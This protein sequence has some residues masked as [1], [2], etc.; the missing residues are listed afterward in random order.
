[1]EPHPLAQRLE[2]VHQHAVAVLERA[3]HVTPPLLRDWIR[4]EPTQAAYLRQTW[5]ELTSTLGELLTV[6]AD[7]QA[8]RPR[9]QDL[10]DFAPHGYLITDAAG[11]IQEANEAA[12]QLFALPL[13]ELAGKRL[14]D[15]VAP[16]ATAALQQALAELPVT[17]SSRRRETRLRPTQGPPFAGAYVVVPAH[18]GQGQVIE[19]R[20]LVWDT[21]EP[22]RQDQALQLARQA[23]EQAAERATRLQAVIARLVEALTADQVLDTVVHQGAAALGSVAGVLNLLTADGLHLT[24]IG[25]GHPE[26]ILEPYRDF[27][28]SAA[29]P[30]ADVLRSGQPLWIESREDFSARYPHLAES[31]AHAGVE[32]VAV[33]PLSADQHPIGALAVS[34]PKPRDFPPE[35]QAYLVALAQLSAQTLARHR[36]LAAENAQLRHDLAARAERQAASDRDLEHLRTYAADLAEA[37]EDERRRLAL[38]LHDQLGGALTG[39]KMDVYLLRRALGEREPD[40]AARLESMSASLTST[41]GLVRSLATEL[42]P[43]M[44]DDL[45][46]PAALEWAAS[47]FQTRFGIACHW[48]TNT[49]TVSLDSTHATAVFRVVQECLTNIVRHAQATAVTI[50]VDAQPDA[51]VVAVRDN[52]RGFAYDPA[53]HLRSL[54]LA[55]IHERVRAIGGE[56]AIKT[57]PGQGTRVQVR[58]GWPPAPGPAL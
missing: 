57:A 44:L 56:V 23:A 52:G 46:L 8:Q 4:P 32:A 21:S 11:L 18:D 30:G 20:W 38:E 47:E 5:H 48:V 42:R 26:P 16:E 40:A 55:G 15:L 43:A 49:E 29:R 10:V 58:L 9:Y 24:T 28:I 7:A 31:G 53:A 51:L 14:T 3:Q 6:Y 27:P 50:T 2:S 36:A 25:I 54:G 35:D 17:I 41:L 22:N 13:A 12:A 45:G 34:F 33:L 1:M 37:R 39:L 19:L